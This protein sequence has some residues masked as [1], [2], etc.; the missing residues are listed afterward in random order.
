MDVQWRWEPEISSALQLISIGELRF[1]VSPV[2]MTR[3]RGFFGVQIQV[4]RGSVFGF[5]FSAFARHC[6]HRTLYELPGSSVATGHRTGKE[7]HG[8]PQGQDV[9]RC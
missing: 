4:E 7:K 8:A 3:F 5:L 6:E 2:H 1:F 9:G